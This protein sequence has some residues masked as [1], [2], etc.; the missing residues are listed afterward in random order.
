MCLYITMP[1]DKFSFPNTISSAANPYSMPYSTTAN[2][3]LPSEA[4]P[5][6]LWG[7]NAPHPSEQVVGMTYTLPETANPTWWKGDLM[8]D[9]A[10]MVNK[11]AA[12]PTTKP[13]AFYI[14]AATQSH[15]FADAT[16]ENI[17]VGGCAG[18]AAG[19]PH[20][21]V[22]EVCQAKIAGSFSKGICYQPA[23]LS[24]GLQCGRLMSITA[25]YGGAK[26]NV[27]SQPSR[28]PA[29]TPLTMPGRVTTPALMVGGCMIATDDYFTPTAM[30]HVPS[31]CY[32]PADLPA[33]QKGCMFPGAL[34][35]APGALQPEKCLYSLV[36]C[37]SQTALNYNSEA[38]VNDGN[39]CVEPVLGCSLP[40]ADY[41]GVDPTTPGYKGRAVGTP[42]ATAGGGVVAYP[43]YG[44]VLNAV[45]GA[46]VLTA[47]AVAVE[48]C[49]DETAVN[50][51]PLATVNTAT[52]CIPKVYG[53]M[54]PSPTTVATATAASAGTKDGGS[55]N[56][57]AIATVNVKTMC[58][59]GR[60][61]CTDV[62]AFNYDPKATIDDGSC[63]PDL[64]G[65]LDPAA[66]NFNCTYKDVFE[67][68][69]PVRALVPTRHYADIC[70]YFLSPP[71]A[72]APGLPPNAITV[73]VVKVTLIAAGDVADFTEAKIA[74][75]KQLIADQAKVPIEN[76]V[77]TIKAA[78]V[79]ITVEIAV[80]DTPADGGATSIAEI[81]TNM[82]PVTTSAE[83]ATSFLSTAGVQVIST[84]TVVQTVMLLPGP[85]PPPPETPVG[86][87]VGGTVGGLFGV[88]MLFFGCY[89]MKMK[90][91]KATY[92]A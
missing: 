13:D 71:P 88:L 24:A 56:Y 51:D 19:N 7:A 5:N 87:I 16:C 58:N 83:A 10:I 90:K 61:G 84:P 4:V 54:M 65:C 12:I 23:D 17:G 2:Y 26:T 37:M 79:E 77:I 72:G 89:M 41:A 50:Y 60:L 28:C 1:Y 35:Y 85:P 39:M 75:M 36:G 73:P 34:N 86:A 22:G 67:P 47:C 53:C 92:P 68:C 82:A 8:K 91:Q 45:A 62:T 33:G 20:G 70:S 66:L 27:A 25:R 38:S 64:Y 59:V 31:M 44:S 15:M 80:P 11:T 32:L 74:E 6:G 40:A 30:V 3:A 55:G 43:T 29:G 49:R 46:N 52:W 81:E 69:T 14:G 9:S 18:P 21:K 57:S 78:S 48:G 63:Y 42:L 76:V